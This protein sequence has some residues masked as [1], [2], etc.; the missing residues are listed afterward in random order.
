M[1]HRIC[2]FCDNEVRF[3]RTCGYCKNYACDE[4]SEKFLYFSKICCSKCIDDYING[5]SKRILKMKN[6]CKNTKKEKIDDIVS[7]LDRTINNLN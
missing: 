2:S 3:I 1:F 5:V 4:C 6:V 7:L